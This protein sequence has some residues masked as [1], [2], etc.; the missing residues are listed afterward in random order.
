M[1]LPGA[2]DL[3]GRIAWLITAVAGMPTVITGFSML[4]AVGISVTVGLIFGLYP[5]RHAANLDPIEALRHE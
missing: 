3:W 5:A 4:L 2:A 1:P